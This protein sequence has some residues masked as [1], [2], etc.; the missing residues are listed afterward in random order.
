MSTAVVKNSVILSEAETKDAAR[1][2]GVLEAQP[3]GPASNKAKRESGGGT[4]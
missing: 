3:K 2:P 1:V 4:L